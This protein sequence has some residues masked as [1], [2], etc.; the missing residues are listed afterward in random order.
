VPLTPLSISL[1]IAV[2]GGLWLLAAVLFQG[3]DERA[4][5][6]R[7]GD[8]GGEERE[9]GPAALLRPLW[10]DPQLQRFIVS[11]GLL[12]STALAPPFVVMLSA[13]ASERGLAHL[14]PLVLSAS[15]ASIVSSYVW[16]RLSDRSSR[17]TMMVA[18][19]L[20][21]LALGGIALVGAWTGGL[22]GAAGAVVAVFVVQ[23]AY[24]GARAGRKLHLTDMAGDDQRARYTALSNTIIAII[25][26]ATS[27]IGAV[28]QSAGVPAVLGLLAVASG[29]SV[30]VTAGLEDVQ[31][32]DR[33]PLVP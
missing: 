4:S 15:A 26:L 11:R 2:A 18:G 20:A 25:L 32:A 6:E 23:I 14:G 27:G 5:D 7:A 31:R 16:G 33:S 13:T 3:L 21:T 17:L 28:A 8:T 19:A 24:E 22:G 9:R 12:T 29:V 1:A 30:V 10:R